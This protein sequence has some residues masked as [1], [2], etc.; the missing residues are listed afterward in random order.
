MVAWGEI[1]HHYRGRVDM[2]EQVH[3]HPNVARPSTSDRKSTYPTLGWWSL[4]PHL[5]CCPDFWLRAIMVPARP[6]SSVKLT[7]VSGEDRWG[8]QQR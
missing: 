4:V 3:F 8:P 1:P 5:W 7:V 6:S 2:V